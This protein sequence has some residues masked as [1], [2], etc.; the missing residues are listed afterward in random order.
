MFS[1]R[2]LPELSRQSKMAANG[3]V[4][5]NYMFTDTAGVNASESIMQLLNFEINYAT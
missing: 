5:K 3:V 2:A 1:Q 4:V